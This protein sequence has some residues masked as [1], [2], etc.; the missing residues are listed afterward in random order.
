MRSLAP[1]APYLVGRDQTNPCP[2]RV[3]E[4][5]HALHTLRQ[6]LSSTGIILQ[7]PLAART[8][9]KLPWRHL[10][11][12]FELIVPETE[13]VALGISEIRNRRGGGSFGPQASAIP[14]ELIR[15]PQ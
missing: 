1:R 13:E 12:S 6:C 10:S 14:I 8:S 9:T 4:G 7:I 3:T 15:L 5:K 2:P 11:V